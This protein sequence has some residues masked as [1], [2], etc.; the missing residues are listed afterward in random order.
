VVQQEL[1]DIQ[2]SLRG[3]YLQRRQAG[4]TEP[5]VNILAFVELGGNGRG[6]SASDGNRDRASQA[7][8]A[9]RAAAAVGNANRFI[10]VL[11]QFDASRVHSA[12]GKR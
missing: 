7:A 1:G 4:A 2:A 9:R 11:N 5:L 3:G 10:G 6:V 12:G 8:S